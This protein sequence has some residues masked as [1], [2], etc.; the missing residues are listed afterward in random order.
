MALEPP[1]GAKRGQRS[2]AWRWIGGAALSLV[3]VATL[4]SVLWDWNWFRPLVEARA[5][6]GVGR[7]VTIERL[8]VHPGLSTRIIAHGLQ[9]ANPDGFEGP[10][11]ANFPRLIVT[12]DAKT[13]FKTRRIVLPVVQADRPTYNF[14]QTADGQNNWT[15]AIPSM[16]DAA[17]SDPPPVEVGEVIIDGGTGRFVSAR[18]PA[19]IAMDLSTGSPPSGA[20]LAAPI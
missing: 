16:F 7:K 10:A 13:W 15:L 2:A 6:A 1:P 3:I 11:F 12:F 19:D 4:V 9:V 17:P 14:L 20:G 5:S 8:E 18:V